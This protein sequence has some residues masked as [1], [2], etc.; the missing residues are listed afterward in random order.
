MTL[1]RF[2]PK[3]DTNERQ[4]IAMLERFGY[5]C[6]QLSDKN[7][8]DL[9]AAKRGKLLLVEVKSGSKKLTEGQQQFFY[10]AQVLGFPAYVVRELKDIELM[11]NAEFSGP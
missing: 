2:N 3:R 8:P 9:L 1:L 6:W 11:D 5:T 10:T 7:I 4:V